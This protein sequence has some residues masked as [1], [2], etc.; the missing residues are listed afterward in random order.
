[1][2]PY[3]RQTTPLFIGFLRDPGIFQWNPAI[4]KRFGLPRDNYFQ[5]RIEAINGANHPNF[6][7]ANT[8]VTKPATFSPTTSWTGF[9]TLPTSSNTNPRQM[10]ISGKFVF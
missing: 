5:L 3:E 8:D 4:S 10:F 7:G 6:G 9:G 2:R 1:M